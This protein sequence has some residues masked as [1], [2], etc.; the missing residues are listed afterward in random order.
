M[1]EIQYSQ[2]VGIFSEDGKH[3]LDIGTRAAK[4]NTPANHDTWAT[5]LVIKRL[6][7]ESSGAVSDYDVVGLF[8]EDGKFRLDIGTG[9]MKKNTPADHESWAT[10]LLIRRLDG[11][12]SGDVCYGH[13]VGVFSEDGKYRLD[14]GTGAVKKNAAADHDTWATRLRIQDADP[15]V[16]VEIVCIDYDLDKARILGSGPVELYR[17][18]VRNNSSVP[19]TSSIKG[20]QS[21][22]ETSGWSDSRGFKIG[23]KTEFKT[24]IPFIAEGKVEVS[25]EVSN[26]YTW[27]ESTKRSQAWS[28]DTPVTVPP[29]AVIVAL[30]SVKVS[31]LSVPYTLKGTFVH[32]SGARVDGSISGIYTGSNSHDL[33]VTY[34]QQDP[35]SLEVS[36]S[37]EAI[38]AIPSY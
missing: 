35:V 11:E 30:V 31:T 34:L 3:R 26:T 29:H 16:D 20:S 25:A 8:S 7:G 15:I 22:E 21:V 17:Q 14:I 28:F 33:Q 38:K 36:T 19:Q 23:V 5:R 13:V 37:I 32:K 6:D 18:Q 2:L 10:R 4:K 24:G 12:S 9:A 1:S 27:N